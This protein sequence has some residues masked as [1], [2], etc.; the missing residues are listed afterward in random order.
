M[1]IQNQ[2]KRTY[3]LKVGVI[4]PLGVIE[5]PDGEAEAI[6]KAGLGELVALEVAKPAKEEA[7]KDEKPTSPEAELDQDPLPF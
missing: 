3:E 2:S 7:K 5:V 6:L 1:L 4:R